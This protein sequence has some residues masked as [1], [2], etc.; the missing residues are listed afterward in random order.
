MNHIIKTTRFGEIE[1][2]EDHLIN[3]VDGIIGFP[4]L[5]RY[6]L[7]ESNIIP[8]IWWLQSMDAP[9]VAFPVAEPYFFKRDYK[10]VMTDAD[11]HCLQYEVTDRLKVLNILTIPTE[12]A[13]MTVNLKAPV[14]I[15]IQKATGTQVIMQDK[16]LEVRTPAWEKFNIAMS[17][18]AIEQSVDD[19][20]TSESFNA[21]NV[22]R[23]EREAGI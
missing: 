14:V 3:F 17:S 22:R 18:F 1:I 9:E 19:V 13:R 4:Q 5:K 12:M 2:S 6:V 16:T 20:G 23:E 7:I 8:L 15:D 11:R 21:V 10:V